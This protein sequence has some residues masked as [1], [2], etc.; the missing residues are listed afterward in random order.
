MPDPPPKPFAALPPLKCYG[1]ILC[2]AAY[3]IAGRP[4]LIIVN[5]FHALGVPACPC[6]FPKITIIYTVTEG[7]GTYEIELAVVHART[8]QDVMTAKDQYTVRDPLSIGDVQIILNGVPLPEAGK[9]WIELRC[10]GE[11]IG[12]RPFYVEVM[13]AKPPPE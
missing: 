9:Y 4:N 13:R 8:G 12:Q 3:R 7:H 1:I 5:T 6:R 11:L 10:N 2:E